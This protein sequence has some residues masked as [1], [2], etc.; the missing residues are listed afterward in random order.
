MRATWATL[1]GLIA[2]TVGFTCNNPPSRDLQE[3]LSVQVKQSQEE[4]EPVRLD[5]LWIVDNSAS[6][7]QEQN[8]LAI[9]FEQFA[10]V[11]QQY[12]K[13]DIRVAVTT[14]DVL[15]DNRQGKFNREFAEAFPMPCAERRMAMCQYDFQ[16]QDA[17]LDLGP[18]W[19]CEEAPSA[20]GYSAALNCNGSLNTACRYQCNGNE[21]CVRDWGSDWTCLMHGASVD[22]YGCVKKPATEDCP[23]NLPPVLK[24]SATLTAEQVELLVTPLT[25]GG[26][27]DIVEGLSTA[28]GA[29]ATYTYACSKC[30]RI[31][32]LLDATTNPN[33]R[34][35]LQEEYDT[36]LRDGRCTELKGRACSV[37]VPDDAQGRQLCALECV[38]Q[39]F[40]RKFRCIATVG[41]DQSKKANLEA[42]M[43]AAWMA[44]DPA[45]SNAQQLCQPKPELMSAEAFAAA[46]AEQ[47]ALEL[48]RRQLLETCFRCT[49]PDRYGVPV[50]KCLGGYA[51][52]CD[53]LNPACRRFLREDS[54]LVIVFVG[55]EDDCSVDEGK[56]I[57]AED[58]PI[59]A[60][61]GDSDQDPST[62][63]RDIRNKSTG[64]FTGEA[65]Y[66]VPLAPVSKYYNR[67]KTVLPD[68]ARVLVAAI[69]GDAYECFTHE[70]EAAACFSG[71]FDVE[72]WCHDRFTDPTDLNQ[73]MAEFQCYRQHHNDHDAAVAC[74]EGAS[75]DALLDCYK[76]ATTEAVAQE[77]V[78]TC[79]AAYKPDA[80]FQNLFAT[81]PNVVDQL[82]AP[83]CEPGEALSGDQVAVYRERYRYAKM[84]PQNA[85]SVNAYVC[86][87]DLG[88][89]DYGGR[90]IQLV[91]SFGPN[92]FFQN[93]CSREGIGPALE[94]IALDI[95][96]RILK[97]C[98]PQ[99]VE[100]REQVRVVKVSP[101]RDGGEIKVP[102]I[103]GAD[104]TIE[105]ALEC[106]TNEA[107]FFNGIDKLPDPKDRLEIY[108]QVDQG[109]LS[110]ATTTG[111]GI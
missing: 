106:D 9:S 18:R 63:P 74:L 68:P 33:T 85:L 1:A 64:W 97:V 67:F 55:D 79:I 69:S 3:S 50:D 103:Y 12:L 82:R 11:I 37:I 46:S 89:A 107:I 23:A 78:A 54:Y 27:A 42:G 16:C 31:K 43:K 86:T 60:V 5:F 53:A 108:Y 88:K 25:S 51:D 6:M 59:C 84:D 8:Q 90:F 22:E 32:D 19:V 62:V 73:C 44:I 36:C 4:R 83:V 100:N 77:A 7:C 15:N 57:K 13:A 56:D 101:L 40:K 26:T 10:D 14:T 29:C 87:S 28:E 17:P 92:G 61:M 72:Y 102:L 81:Q 99:P 111:G 98:L 45:G 65:K 70:D 39:D 21:D 80:D 47:K 96:P 91:N 93:I 104:F 110:G 20:S 52:E 105:P 76:E 58:Y 95:V 109:S 49:N 38:F 35:E 34:A 41:A 30:D 48:E 75:E 2:A 24:Y 94:S 71:K 66:R